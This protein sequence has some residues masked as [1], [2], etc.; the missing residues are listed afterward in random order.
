MDD[1]DVLLSLVYVL[2]GR[3]RTNK[4]AKANQ[5]LGPITYRSSPVSFTQCIPGF[6]HCRREGTVQGR[7][8]E[9]RAAYLSLLGQV[10]RLLCHFGS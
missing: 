5:Q 6:G 10:P 4:R 9:A 7:E 1:Y 2:N 8:E 3:E